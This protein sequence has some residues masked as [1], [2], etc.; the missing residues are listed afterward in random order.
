MQDDVLILAKQYAENLGWRLIPLHAVGPRAKRPRGS[1]WPE[2]ATNVVSRIENW[3][4]SYADDPEGVSFGLVTGEASG[5][6]VVDIDD[7]DKGWTDLLAEKG[8]LPETVVSITGSGGRH[9]F[10]SYPPDRV[11]SSGT[12]VPVKGV[13]IRAEGGQ[14]VLPPAP[15][16]SGNTYEW[17]NSPFDTPLAECPAWL[18]KAIRDAAGNEDFLPLDAVW[19]ERQ[20]DH[21]FHY[22]RMLVFTDW[23]GDEIRQHFLTKWRS[24]EIPDTDPSN[25]WSESALLEPVESGIKDAEDQMEAKVPAGGGANGTGPTKPLRFGSPL[26]LADEDNAIRLGYYFDGKILYSTGP[27]WHVWD[28]QRWRH[29]PEALLV[30]RL[31]ERTTRRIQAEANQHGGKDAQRL[32]TWAKQSRNLPRIRAMV[33]LARKLDD[34]KIEPEDLDPES[35]TDLLNVQNGTLNLRTLELTTPNPMDRITKVT[36]TAWDAEA[37]CPEWMATLGYAFNGDQDLIGFFQRAIGYSLTG[38]VPEHVFICWG[39]MGL[40]GKSTILENLYSV[41]GQD[42]GTSFNARAVMSSKNDNF[43]LS[44]LAGMRGSRFATASETGEEDFLNEDL[45]KAVTG[46]DTLSVKFMRMDTFEYQP[47]FKLWVRTNN[48]PRVKSTDD[49]IWRRLILIPFNH[50]IPPSAVKPRYVVDRMLSA[51]SE[52]ILRWACEGA[53]QFFERGF[54]FPEEVTAATQEYRAENDPIGQFVEERCNIEEGKSCYRSEFKKQMDYWVQ[55]T[56]NWRKGPSTM[57]ITSYLDSRYGIEAN[58]AGG[59]SQFEGIELLKVK[60]E[61][62]GT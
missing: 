22:A 34:V 13:D 53:Q 25:K 28:L 27:G 40:N 48:K 9:Y 2:R 33:S 43:A 45:V 42:Y 46:G 54:D 20:N 8:D 5:V 23:S 56:Y 47:R 31:A 14:C 6:F 59:N 58:S 52:G 21:L 51:E 1:R 57:K 36:P 39:A 37:A 12:G 41:I 55:D 18:L 15:H 17:H 24:G 29:D 30:G 19:D 49:P 61:W 35:T 62:D 11:V 16:P 10:F 4:A 44:T 26:G 7:P 60:D 32:R 50:Q 3:A 38:I